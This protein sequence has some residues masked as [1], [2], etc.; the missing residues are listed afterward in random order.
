MISINCHLFKS[1]SSALIDRACTVWSCGC[2]V[3][4]YNVPGS[5]DCTLYSCRQ[6]LVC[7]RSRPTHFL[8]VSGMKSA[9]WGPFW[10]VM[11]RSIL[12]DYSL[13]DYRQKTCHSYV[14]RN[15]VG[16]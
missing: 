8:W 7:H 12:Y 11:D 16:A 6:S 10:F 2:T 9:Q 3:Y 4:M 1:V 14:S 5:H 13:E 15:L